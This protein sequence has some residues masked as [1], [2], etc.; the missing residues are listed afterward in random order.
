MMWTTGVRAHPTKKITPA[1]AV[2]QTSRTHES[3]RDGGLRG[4][5]AVCSGATIY[6]KA[7]E[8]GEWCIDPIGPAAVMVCHRFLLHTASNQQHAC[9][10][11]RDERSTWV[12]NRPSTCQSI[13]RFLIV[14]AQQKGDLSIWRQTFISFFFVRLNSNQWCILA[15]DGHL[16]Q[17]ARWSKVH[18]QQVAIRE[19]ADPRCP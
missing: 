4:L 12:W 1:P 17:Y 7:K 3:A 15:W 9:N 8:R 18:C 10:C 2:L 6:W 11:E 5:F 13:Q 19:T 14:R 16:L